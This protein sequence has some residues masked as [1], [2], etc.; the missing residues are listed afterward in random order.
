LVSVFKSAIDHSLIQHLDGNPVHKL[1]VASPGGKLRASHCYCYP[2]TDDIP[3]DAAS[4]IGV[5]PRVNLDG[6]LNKKSFRSIKGGKSIDIIVDAAAMYD[7]SAGGQFDIAAEGF[8]PFAGKNKIDG[9][10][11]YK[12]NSISL[13]INGTEAAVAKERVRQFEKRNTLDADCTA[14]RL[15]ASVNALAVCYQLA[16]VAAIKAV[17]G[18]ANQ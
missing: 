18:D 7:L 15:D 3:G 9:E 6:K 4:F 17:S 14:G 12:S 13:Q 11:A 10:A 5:H 16:T 8:L 2:H 1:D